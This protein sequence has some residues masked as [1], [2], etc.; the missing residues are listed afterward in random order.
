MTLS[1]NYKA[2]LR[3]HR[4]GYRVVDGE[5]ISP[6]SGKVLNI[7]TRL[8]SGRYKYKRFTVGGPSN[9]RSYVKVALLVAYQKFGN[10]VFDPNIVVRHLDGNSLNNIEENIE[11]GSISD[12][13][14][15]RPTDIRVR[16]SVTAATKLRK[17]TDDE[18]DQI[19]SFHTTSSSYTETMEEFNITSKGSLWYILNNRYK[20]IK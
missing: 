7:K 2:V 1:N 4:K 11:I 9:G 15:D 13:M 18:I 19:R 12:N 6:Y 14:L 20:T 5:V 16:C 3:A 17:F 10:I 8:S